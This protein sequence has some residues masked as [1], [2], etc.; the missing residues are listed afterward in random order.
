MKN[1]KKEQKGRNFTSFRSFEV[2]FFDFSGL[3]R[4]LLGIY[5]NPIHQITARAVKVTRVS[6]VMP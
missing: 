5:H 4:L 1:P 2:K 6:M 3:H